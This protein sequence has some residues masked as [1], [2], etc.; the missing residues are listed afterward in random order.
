MTNRE[1][2]LKLSLCESSHGRLL[3]ILPSRGHLY[4]QRNIFL[5]TVDFRFRRERWALRMRQE[6]GQWTL[7]AKGPSRRTGGISD[8]IEIE[9]SITQEQ[10]EVWLRGDVLLSELRMEPS[11]HLLEMFGDLRVSP[12]LSFDN[13]RQVLLFEGVALELDASQC[14]ESRRYELELELPRPEL[15]EVIPKL[16]AFFVV[17]GLPWQPSDQSKLA[18]AIEHHGKESNRAL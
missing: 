5:D 15:D 3:Q 1:V 12:W 9:V 11:G 18:W 17:H 16:N 13:Q 8:R 4:Q 14:S 6:D 10:A 2:E 7:A